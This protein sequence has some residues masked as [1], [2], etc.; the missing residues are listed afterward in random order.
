VN[1]INP[2]TSEALDALRQLVGEQ[3]LLTDTESLQHYGRDWTRYVDPA[4]TAIVLPETVEEVQAI[5]RLAREHRFALV[6]S[7]GRTG[8]SGG[9]TAATGE[10]VLSLERMNKVIDLNRT[11]RSMT[12]QAGTITEVVQRLAE[13]AGLHYPVDFASKGSSQIGGNIATNAG[14]IQVIRYGMTR[15]WV[16]GLK[17]VTGTGEVLDL[18]RGLIKNNTG[19][20]FRHLF[21][22][23]EGVL[24]VI[25]E[26]TLGLC[27]PPSDPRVIVLGVDSLDAI[28]KVLD[29]FQAR[30]DLLAYEFFS[31]NALAKVVEHQGLQRPFDSQT[32]YYALLEFEYAGEPTEL[33]IAEVLEPLMEAGVV[34]DAVL[35]QS[36][37]QTR[38]LWRLREDISETI[39]RWTPYKNDISTTVSRVPGF[40]SAVDALVAD[41]YPD[42]EV[43]WF[44]H[45]GDGNLHLNILRPETLSIDEF[46]RRCKSVSEKIFEQIAAMGGSISAEHGVGLLKKEFLHYSRSEPEIQMMRAVKAAF[47]PDNIMNPG[48]IFDA[49]PDL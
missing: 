9:A 30:M 37:A 13:E 4:P 38:S 3:R 23:S 39:S 44:G 11:D 18:N 40:L 47:D 25:V 34:I 41:H 1:V 20:D 12:V 22:G 29:A 46:A 24:G 17:V 45:I 26:A 49:E 19:L 14:G 15:E 35:S 36:V 32:P 16:R 43:V 28:M 33:L 7:G 10:L 2:P 42:L 27:A 5:V 21:I 48:K 8:L 6:P 31:D